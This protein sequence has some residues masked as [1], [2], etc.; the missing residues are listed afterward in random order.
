MEFPLEFT[1][2]PNCG[3]PDRVIQMETEEAIIKGD[4]KEGTR[5][6]VLVTRALIYD[7]NAF[8]RIH[9]YSKEV[10]VIFG[11]YD[12]CAVCGTLYC[13]RMDKGVAKI[14]AQKEKPHIVPPSFMGM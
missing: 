10:P 6:P 11:A 4:L 13:T 9:G 5:I 2:C 7:P 14:E 3:S 1:K 8:P 12:V